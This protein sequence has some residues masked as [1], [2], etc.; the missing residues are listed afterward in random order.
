MNAFAMGGAELL[1]ILVV[2]VIV[3]GAVTIGLA[4]VFA[5]GRKSPTT[6]GTNAKTAES[7]LREL[8]GLRESGLVTEEEY[9]ESRA[10]ILKEV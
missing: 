5:P 4:C 7:R 3:A 8:D 1:V 6:R 2:S 10:A 9:Q